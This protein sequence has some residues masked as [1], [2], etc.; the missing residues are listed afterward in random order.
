MTVPAIYQGL[1]RRTGIWRSNGTSDLSTQ[2][3]WFQS[4][5]F[6]IDLRIPID[7]PSMD[8]RA[9]LARLAPAQLARFSAQ[10]GCAGKTV[11]TG[12]RCEWR[13]EI[14]FPALSADLDAGWMR[15]DSEDAVHETGIDNSYEEDWIR[16][17][18]APM[19]GV[20]LEATG[21]PVLAG[22]AGSPAVAYL[23]IGERWMAWA[24]GSPSDAYSPGTPDHG[25][26]SEFTVLHKG[27]DWRIAGSN[28]AWL[29][30]QEVSDA[31]ALA[32]QPLSPAEITTLP[33]APGHWRVTALA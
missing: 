14:A 7:R 32:A 3:W 6:H 29:E 5:S 25:A 16:M 10:T 1:W 12:D 27:G 2:V 24:C 9:Q 19:R 18:S 22:S 33:F 4:A 8:S 30:G 17:A 21:S 26:W 31:D 28:C 23:I 20:R 15:F 11:V 13:P